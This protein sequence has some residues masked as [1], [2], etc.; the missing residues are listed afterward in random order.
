MARATSSTGNLNSIEDCYIRVG[1][2]IIYMYSLP[3]ISD[4]HGADYAAENGIGRSIPTQ[5]FQHGT[6]RTI[7]WDVTF[8]A[9][10]ESKLNR[11]LKQLPFLPPKILKITCGKLL[12]DYE[13]CVIL[14]QISVQWPTDVPWSSFSYIPYKFNANCSFEVVYNSAELPGQSR[15]LKIGL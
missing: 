4:S 1:S 6:S 8:I 10:G 14:K 7:S 12:G 2:D 3:Q 15:I 11:N 9:D 13:L 5:A